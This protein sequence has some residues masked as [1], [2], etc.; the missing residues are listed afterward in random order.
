M[1]RIF[2]AV[3]RALYDTTSCAALYQ[4]SGANAAAGPGKR[5][6]MKRGRGR[7][8]REG[9][10]QVAAKEKAGRGAV[11]GFEDRLNT[12]VAR[13]FWEATTRPSSN[14]E[15][16]LPQEGGQNG[17]HSVFHVFALVFPEIVGAKGAGGVSLCQPRV[18]LS[19]LRMPHAVHR[20]SARAGA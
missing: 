13:V 1:T 12:L 4:Q 16:I 5:A 17:D 9:D 3:S 8:A 19:V 18:A 14:S 15:D 10:G 6:D 7:E 20:A 11:T 2:L